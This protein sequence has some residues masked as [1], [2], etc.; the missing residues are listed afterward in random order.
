MLEESVVVRDKEIIILKCL[1]I[2]MSLMLFSLTAFIPLVSS[3]AVIVAYFGIKY[4]NDR[5]CMAYDYVLF[6][7]VLRVDRVCQKKVETGILEVDVHHI[8]AI[9][10]YEPSMKGGNEVFLTSKSDKRKGFSQYMISISSDDKTYIISLS[11]KMKNKLL[12]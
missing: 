4:I 12:K 1:V 2:M 6:Q 3:I 11:E 8:L 9:L 5:V 7:Q 10:P